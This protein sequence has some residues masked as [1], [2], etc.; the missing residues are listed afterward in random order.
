[1]GSCLV[2]YKQHKNF[3]GWRRGISDKLSALASYFN[4]FTFAR[5]SLKRGFVGEGERE[6]EGGRESRL[7]GEEQG[8]MF[9]H[10]QRKHGEGRTPRKD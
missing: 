7:V 9:F 1:M 6:R 8:H 4:W 3:F 2:G 5:L 10:C